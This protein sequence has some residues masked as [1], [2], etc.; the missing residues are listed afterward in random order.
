MYV[1]AGKRG[2]SKNL[3]KE[4]AMAFFLV[5]HDNQLTH[6]DLKPEN[7]LFVNSDYDLLPLPK[8]TKDKVEVC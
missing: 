4:R 5:L 8:K 3:K 2:A 6:T 1:L 7:I